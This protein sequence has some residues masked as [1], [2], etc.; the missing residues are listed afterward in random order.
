MRYFLATIFVC[1][2]AI[3]AASALPI[4]GPSALSWSKANPIAQV[5]KHNRSNARRHSHGG[6]GG[7]HPLVGSGDY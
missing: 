5:A 7:I 4:F 3:P 6:N 1:A 2:F